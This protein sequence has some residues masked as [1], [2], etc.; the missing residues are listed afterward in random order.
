M[1]RTTRFAASVLALGLLT[2]FPTMYSNLASPPDAAAVSGFGDVAAGSDDP[3]QPGHCQ[4]QPGEPG[5]G[6]GGEPGQPGKCKPGQPGQPGEPG[7]P[8]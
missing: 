8:G 1:T 7:Q 4:A 3:G 2:V 6:D 5:N